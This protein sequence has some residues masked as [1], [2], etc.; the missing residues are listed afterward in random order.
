M[1]SSGPP[2][3]PPNPEPVEPALAGD[4]RPKLRVGRLLIRVAIVLVAAGAVYLYSRGAPPPSS[5]A[6]VN[7]RAEAVQRVEIT[8]ESGGRQ[9]IEAIDTLAPG[10]MWV[11]TQPS[12]ASS[13]ASLS[14][15]P[16][17]GAP[18]SHADVGVAGPGQELTVTIGPG[19][20]ST[21]VQARA[22]EGP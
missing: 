7:G 14:Y 16:E 8:V 1:V 21:D 15:T 19:G 5:V 4:D 22:A 11:F 20:L 3:T 6:I 2:P 12:Q 17:G 18:Q 13:V 10:S 9:A